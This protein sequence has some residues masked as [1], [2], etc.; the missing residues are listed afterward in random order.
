VIL[1]IDPGTIGGYAILG[2]DALVELDDL[3]VHQVGTVGKKVLR[4]ELSIHVL[5]GILAKHPIEHCFIEQTSAMPK[6][7]TVS[8]FRFGYACGALYGVIAA[9]GVAVSF[10]QPKA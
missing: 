4:S 5:G 6:Q 10:V 2:S 1:G 8:T 3:P 9:L 7:G